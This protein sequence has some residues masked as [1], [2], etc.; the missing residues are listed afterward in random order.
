[1]APVPALTSDEIATL[2]DWIDQ[3]AIWTSEADSIS[4][5]T[6]APPAAPVYLN[7]YYKE[8]V[9]TDKDR[10]AWAY[11]KPVRNPVPAVSDPRW[12]RNPIDA[13]VRKAAEAKGLEPA[14]QADKRT[15]IRRAYLDLIGLLP[16]PAEVDA[17][18][19]NTAPDAYEK[20]VDRL[21]A[22]PNYG[23]RWGRFWLDV[24]RYADSSGFEY[25]RDILNA[26]RYRDYVIKAFN[27]DRP[28]NKFVVEQLAGDELDQPT[29]D[30]SDRN[31]LL[32]DWSA[33]SVPREAESQQPLRL[34]G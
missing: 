31:V 1:M 20:L 14:P 26:W 2:K 10:Q 17:F 21:L 8:R 13:F 22:S 7:G 27:E 30:K 5:V 19:N 29:N 23:E 6:P 12:S 16:P 34:H 25:D 33:S 11:Q 18:V 24:V 28:F 15:L 9:I 3:G 4:A 32:S